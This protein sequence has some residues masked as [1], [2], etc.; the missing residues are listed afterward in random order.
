MARPRTPRAAFGA[1]EMPANL[2]LRSLDADALREQLAVVGGVAEEELGRLGPLEVQVR[3]VLPRE[4]D[5]TVDL[6]VLGGG[7]EVRLRAV[8]LGQ[9]RDRRQLVVEL[10]RAPTGVVRRR[11]GRL[12]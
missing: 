11:L 2:R 8:R 5:T 4:P 3:G 12:D 10:R 1:V 9:R 6:D 7:V